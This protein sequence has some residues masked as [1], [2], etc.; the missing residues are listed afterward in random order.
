[1]RAKV[2]GWLKEMVKGGNVLFAWEGSMAG[3]LELGEVFE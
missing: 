2:M 3:V 1:M